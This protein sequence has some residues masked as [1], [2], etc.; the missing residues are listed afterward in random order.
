MLFNAYR[1]YPF[2][3]DYYSYVLETTAGEQGQVVDRI[4]TQTPTEIKLSLTTSY[5]GDL[6]IFTK[7]KMQLDGKI[8]NLRDKNGVEIYDD[9]E[10]EITQTQPLTNAMGFVTGYRYRAQIIAG[11]V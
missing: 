11:N 1:T 4:Y 10:W 5:I 9:G 3:A 7:S 2:T 6:L 8:K